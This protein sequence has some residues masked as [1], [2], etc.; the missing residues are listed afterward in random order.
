[1]LNRLP[2]ITLTKS[3][4]SQWKIYVGLNATAVIVNNILCTMTFDIYA[5][6]DDNDINDNNDDVDDNEQDDDDEKEDEDDSEADVEEA[7]EGEG[8]RP[9]GQEKGFDLDSRSWTHSEWALM[10]PMAM[11]KT[12]MRTKM[13]W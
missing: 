1:M 6:S 11:T 9:A 13:T 5:F 8:R 10:I 7:W 2:A 4:T 12:M 3:N